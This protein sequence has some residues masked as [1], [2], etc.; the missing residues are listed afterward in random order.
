[1]TESLVEGFNLD[2]EHRIKVYYD[3]DASCPRGDWSMVT[4]FVKIK[5]A[6]NPSIMD[7]PAVHDDPTGRIVEADS[8]FGALGWTDRDRN[9]NVVRS[10][11]NIG[12]T[13]RT[14]V[15]WARIFH[16]LHVEHDAEHGG[17]WFCDPTEFEANFHAVGDGKVKRIRQVEGAPI[18]TYENY[19]QDSLE[20]QAEVIASERETYRQWAAGEVYGVVLTK[21]TFLYE[22]DDAGVATNRPATEVWDEVESIWGCYLDDKYTAFQVAKDHWTLPDDTESSASRQHYIDTGKYLVIGEEEHGV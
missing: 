10:N 5:G 20:V 12:L 7:V 9:D 17:Y 22:L 16:N 21:R 13:E 1:M 18:N 3:Q 2:E 19:E 15:R 11:Q 6:G 14:V 4:G 8:R